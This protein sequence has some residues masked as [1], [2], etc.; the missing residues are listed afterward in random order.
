MKSQG[1]LRS[2][3]DE[4]HLRKPRFQPDNQDE[5]EDDQRSDRRQQHDCT[6]AERIGEV[7]QNRGRQHAARQTYGEDAV[8]KPRPVVRETV[9]NRLDNQR[10]DR[11]ESEADQQSSER[12]TKQ[13][14]RERKGSGSRK[15]PQ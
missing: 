14:V 4:C 1:R 7:T 13:V 9:P 3:F 2:G 10:I 8:E 12:G 11:S 15:A 6:Q 5:N